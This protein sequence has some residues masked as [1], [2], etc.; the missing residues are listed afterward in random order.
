MNRYGYSLMCEAKGP[1][2]IVDEAR[3]AEEAGFDFV[4][5]SDHMHPWL[6]SQRHSG[7]AWSILG[8]LAQAT[9]EIDLVTMVTCPT[10][11]YHP[12]IVAQKAATVALLS[13]GRF[14]LGL[15]AGERLNEHVTGMPWP[16]VDV[17]HERLAEAIEIIQILHAGGYVTYRGEYF[18]VEDARVFDL[19]DEPVPMFAAASGPRAA[20]VAG[21]GGVGLCNTEPRADVVGAYVDAGGEAADTWAQI[22]LAW[23][24]SEADGLAQALEG[25]KFMVPGWKVMSELPNPI[26]FEAA[27]RHVRADDLAPMMP[28]G[29][30]PAPH[31]QGI[32]RY[33][34][35]GYHHVSVMYPGS[36]LDG[37]FRFWADELHPS[38]SAGRADTEPRPRPLTSVPGR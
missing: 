3:R 17:R 20:R 35:A 23:A 6:Y 37:F 33:H 19:P 32:D 24:P 38:L 10:V 34:E 16:P 26:N 5:I 18:D 22:G 2:Q 30:D 15:G 14:V 36:D 21:Q 8:A 11:R 27:T 9:T 13:G 31:L 4:T 29:P 12:A 25:A 7:Y 1:R 28:A